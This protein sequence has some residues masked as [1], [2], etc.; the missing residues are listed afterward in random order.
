MSKV[1]K[2]LSKR[3]QQ[4]LAVL[5]R[6]FVDLEYFVKTFLGNHVTA[7]IPDFH[8]ELYNLVRSENRLIIA[9]PR[10]FA[11]SYILTVFHTI[12]SICFKQKKTIYIISDS[13]AK[14]SEFMGKIKYELE[15]NPLIREFF[16]NLVGKKWS[17]T[18]IV[19]TTGIAVFAKGA[20]ASQRGPR[21]DLI[22]LDDIETE[23]SVATKERREKMRAYIFKECFNSLTPNGQFLWV[24]TVIS[25]MALINEYLDA[26]N[27]FVKRRYKA[28]IDE[29]QDKDHL[30][31][32]E[33]WPHERLQEQKGII[34][35]NFFATEYLNNPRADDNAPIKDYHIKKWNNLGEVPDNLTCYI[36]VDPAYSEEIASDEKV[37]CL[38]GVDSESRRWLLE[39]IHTRCSLNDFMHAVINLWSDNKNRVQ[40]LG[41]PNKGV[42][43]SF[44][45]SFR[46][47]CDRLQAFPPLCEL[48]DV[49]TSA[50]GV[51]HR[52]KKNRIIAALQ[53]LFEQGR[54]IVGSHHGAA[55]DQLLSIGSSRHDDIVDCMAYAE[56]LISGGAE[57]E[58]TNKVDRYGQP[59]DE[60][61][62]FENWGYDY[63]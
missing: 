62:E 17:E 47:E 39:V 31:W 22:V 25:T 55:I 3:D 30:L 7:T 5:E 45:N 15:N 52:N 63:D 12:W 8:R 53:P 60:F 51:S 58:N 35:S 13:E 18:K 10:G 11:K 44:F 33:L 38:V 19:T 59:V 61:E 2:P 56:Q 40:S 20:E 1:D 37:A 48:G 21:P 49:F 27:T 54:Y 29:V 9:A 36:S 23:A 28:Y 34:G 4:K 16:G 43:K 42:E 24:G 14:A 6:A 26:D 50:T 57:P 46:N 32:P 41:V